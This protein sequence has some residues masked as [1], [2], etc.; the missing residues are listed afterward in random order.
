M[1]L[2]PADSFER[3]QTA[4]RADDRSRR[5]RRGRAAWREA[6]HRRCRSGDAPARLPPFWHR[7]EHPIGYVHGDFGARSTWHLRCFI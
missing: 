4:A 3:L 5:S 2:D 6:S 1:P 7:P